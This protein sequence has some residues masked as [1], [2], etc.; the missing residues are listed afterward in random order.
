M[1]RVK[2]DGSK[3]GWSKK[4]RSEG[5]NIVIQHPDG[6]RAG[7]WHIQHNGAVVNVG[8][9]VKKGQWIALSGKTGY[10]AT[11]HLHFLVWNSSQG[12]QWRQVA[13]RFET[14]QGV[15]YLRAWRSY[16]RGQ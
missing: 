13:T 4:Y 3:G 7:Y 1:I 9:T 8:D 15:K 16:K 5:N 12:G 2:E 10:A 11:P 6:T 14:S